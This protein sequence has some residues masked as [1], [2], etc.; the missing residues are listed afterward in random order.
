MAISSCLVE[1]GSGGGGPAAEVG[2]AAGEDAN[3]AHHVGKVRQRFATRYQFEEPWVRAAYA[4]ETW[5]TLTPEQLV[6][7]SERIEDLVREYDENP[8]EATTPARSPSSPMRRRP[9]HQRDG[10]GA[11]PVTNVVG[12]RPVR[13]A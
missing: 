12:M 7:L 1:I 9:G 6:E 8:A 13:S 10:S 2:V 3:L 11:G 4:T 5:L